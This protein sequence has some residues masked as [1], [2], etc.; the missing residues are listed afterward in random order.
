VP[1]MKHALIIAP[2]N[3]GKIAPLKTAQREMMKK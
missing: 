2:H 3:P 1:D